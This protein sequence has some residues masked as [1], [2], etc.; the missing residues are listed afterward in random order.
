MKVIL[1]NNKGFSL[2]EMVVATAFFVMFMMVLSDAF[3]RIVGK[4]KLQTKLAD[5]NIAGIVGLEMLRSD[6][7]SAGFGLP[8]EFEYRPGP[9]PATASFS[10]SEAADIPGTLLNGATRMYSGNYIDYKSV[11]NAFGIIN[12]N[13]IGNINQVL[14]G[15]DVLAVRAM[16]ISTNAAAK[17][18]TYVTSDMSSQEANN[19]LT[20]PAKLNASD[21]VILIKPLEKDKS[22]NKMIIY[23]P[24]GNAQIA[25]K[26]EKW[27]AKFGLYSSDIG[28]PDKGSP[29]DPQTDFW[30]VYGVHETTT[31]V[32]NL[33]MPFNRADYYVRQPAASENAFFRLPQRCNPATG[34]LMKGIITQS[35][36][37]YLELPIMECVLDMQVRFTRRIPGGG[38]DN[39]VDDL[40]SL[41]LG[42]MADMSPEE[43]RQ[44]IKEVRINIL[45]HDGARDPN[46]NFSSQTIAV[47]NMAD[48]YDFAARG[49]PN[50]QNYR[51]KVYQVVA[52]PTNL[53]NNKS[54]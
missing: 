27:F 47:G 10:Y 34:V 41:S 20:A 29:S 5:T 9:Y 37:Q 21:Q 52:R 43:V 53:A 50:W 1:R 45:T 12:N 54:Q 2:I 46:Y 19:S 39:D 36:G 49:V 15:T 7:E 33:R 40:Q 42:A 13:T 8:W 32:S 25:G 31:S 23:R 24:D 22:V 16:T 18:W 51:W 48:T 4:A 44:Q 30:L 14:P 3:S 11:P 35:T 6:V 17:R 26:S 28:K 38:M